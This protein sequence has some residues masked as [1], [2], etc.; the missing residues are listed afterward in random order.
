FVRVVLRRGAM[1][2]SPFIFLGRS[3]YD[4]S[5]LSS[6]ALLAHELKHLEQYQRY[7]HLRFLIRYFWDLAR[8]RFRYNRQLPLEAEAYD[9]QDNVR[10]ALRNKFV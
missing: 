10:D 5:S 4:P 8:N 6:L 3:L 7:G 2:F 9:L 1:T